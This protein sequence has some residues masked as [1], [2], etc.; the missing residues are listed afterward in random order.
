MELGELSRSKPNTRKGPQSQLGKDQWGS[1]ASDRSVLP[2]SG[3]R[4][5]TELDVTFEKADSTARKNDD[6]LLYQT[7]KALYAQNMVQHY[8]FTNRFC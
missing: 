3:I 2:V 8:S 6:R 4:Q 1:S 7:D 5:T